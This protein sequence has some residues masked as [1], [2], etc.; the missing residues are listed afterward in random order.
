MKALLA[1]LPLL[2][3]C[4][5]ISNTVVDH[6]KSMCSWSTDTTQVAWHE[7]ACA[8]VCAIGDDIGIATWEEDASGVCK[9][10]ARCVLLHPGD[11]AVIMSKTWRMQT[12]VRSDFTL[13]YVDCVQPQEC[14]WDCG[15]H[16]DVCTYC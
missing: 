14:L 8:M 9:D 2:L 6:S 7:T 10:A 15:T 16:D 11:E 4:E 5:Q 12:A 13:Q 1:F 3:G